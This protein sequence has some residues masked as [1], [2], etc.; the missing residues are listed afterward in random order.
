MSALFVNRQLDYF[1]VIHRLQYWTDRARTAEVG[2]REYAL[3]CIRVLHLC[4][5]KHADALYMGPKID[6]DSRLENLV[7]STK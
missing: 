3:S 6:V 5:L 1:E 2:Q 4:L 7:A